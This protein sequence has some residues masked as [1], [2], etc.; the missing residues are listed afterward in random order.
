MAKCK[1][2]G[3]SGKER[4]YGFRHFRWIGTSLEYTT[5]SKCKGKGYTCFPKGTLIRV[6]HGDV[7]IENLRKDDYVMSY[8][9]N[10][11]TLA[12]RKILK[13]NEYQKSPT[14]VIEFTDGKII[15]TTSSHSFLSSHQWKSAIKLKKGDKVEFF[16]KTGKTT[17]IIK[18]SYFSGEME[19]VYNLIVD[20]NF[21]YIANDSIAHS[22]TYF[23][24][25][26]ITVWRIY[27]FL[28][29]SI[30]REKVLSKNYL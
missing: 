12:P 19:S 16:K 18:N 27:G 4:D 22:F 15:K 10:S 30:K 6:R 1:Q 23:R 25:F 21:N 2:C 14:F 20:S 29:S 7:N 3:G 13:I 8:N 5:C 11:K 26:R 9:K 24:N 28:C 17:K